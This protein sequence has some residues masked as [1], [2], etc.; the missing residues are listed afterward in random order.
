[1]A[2]RKVLFAILMVLCLV[3][4]KESPVSGYVVGKKHVPAHTTT[5]YNVTLKMPQV[6]R[7]PEQWVVWVADSCGVHRCNVDKAT[8]DR[9]NRGQFVTSKGV[10][11][12]KESD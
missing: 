10:Y 2:M 11:R 4:C 3:S 12:G 5:H 6:T 1:M 8:F 9:L 7:H